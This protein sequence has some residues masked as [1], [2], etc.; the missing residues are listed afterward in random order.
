[1]LWGDT[2]NTHPGGE[3]LIVEEREQLKGRFASIDGTADRVDMGEDQI[4]RLLSEVIEGGTLRND[5]AEKCVVLFDLRLL[6]RTHGVAEEQR[7]FTIALVIVLKGE[8]IRKLSA[9]IAQKY[10]KQRRNGD[11][12]LTKSILHGGKSGG[13]FRCGSIIHEQTEHK[14]AGGKVN[15]H[16]H[17]APNATDHSIHFNVAFKMMIGDVGDEIIVGTANLDTG[18]N[19]INLVR[20]PG[21]ELY[22]PG[23]VENRSGIIAL[24]EMTVNRALGTGNSRRVGHDMIDVLSLFQAFGDDAVGLIKLLLVQRYAFPGLG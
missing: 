21:L 13:T 15:R 9:I 19:V 14:V 6:G 3:T 10:I 2:T 24:L 1:M 12:R 8:Y 7:D 16:N 18:R 5:V 4:N 23:E 17:F 11:T 20:L 22:S